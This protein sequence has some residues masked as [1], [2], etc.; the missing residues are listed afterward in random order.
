[1]TDK[2]LSLPIRKNI[3]D[4]AEKTKAALGKYEPLLGAP[5][6]CEPDWANVATGLEKD[7]TFKE[8]I[9]EVVFLYIDK[10]ADNL[11]KLDVHFKEALKLAWT[12]K[13]IEIKFGV[14]KKDKPTYQKLVLEGGNLVIQPDIGSP[15]SNVGEIGQKA[16]QELDIR[17]AAGLTPA[18][19]K[20][21]ANYD[22][23]IKASLEG[24]NKAFGVTATFAPDWVAL[25]AAMA[26]GT[27]ENPKWKDRA[28]ELCNG[29]IAAILNNTK[30]IG[31]DDLVKE[32]F[33]EKWK[34]PISVT[35]DKT[36]KGYHEVDFADGTMVIKFR[37][38]ANVAECGKDIEKKL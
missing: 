8:R 31:A 9:G 16:H 25:A 37:D 7:S 11:N 2:N 22:A 15:T 4:H 35:L 36:I 23:K 5:A 14:Y 38:I 29:F 1:M 21:V 20:D 17:T 10:L 27:G 6:T 13:K 3:R 18:L 32:A 30:K 12:T 28:A 26:A 19:A 34:G 33:L 24:L